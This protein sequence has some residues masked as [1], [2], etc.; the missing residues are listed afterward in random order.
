M[1]S[2]SITS[3]A[4]HCIIPRYCGW[5]SMHAYFMRYVCIPYRVKTTLLL[6][7]TTR[8]H[9]KLTLQNHAPCL[10]LTWWVPGQILIVNSRS[11]SQLASFKC[12]VY[13]GAR[14]LVSLF[15]LMHIPCD[16]Q[17]AKYSQVEV[18]N[19]N[20]REDQKSLQRSQFCHRDKFGT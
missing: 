9:D 12:H 3:H 10:T 14:W 2:C 16:H 5:V 15:Q 19:S 7:G 13:I 1:P 20:Q 8:W 17:A 11:Y 4:V 18:S 6:A